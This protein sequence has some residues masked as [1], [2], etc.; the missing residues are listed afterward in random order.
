[1]RP[2]TGEPQAA[3]DP[4]VDEEVAFW[5]GFITWWAQ[6]KPEPVPARAWAALAHAERKRQLETSRL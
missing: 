5:Q 6:E 2:F 1:M 4:A 3:D